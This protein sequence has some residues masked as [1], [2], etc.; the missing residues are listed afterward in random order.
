MKII[1]NSFRNAEDGCCWNESDFACKFL[2]NSPHCSLSTKSL[3]ERLIFQQK[4]KIYLVPL[5]YVRGR[6]QCTNW[7]RQMSTPHHKFD[8]VFQRKWIKLKC[9]EW[10]KKMNSNGNVCQWKTC[11]TAPNG[12]GAKNRIKT[13]FFFLL[14]GILFLLMDSRHG[15]FEMKL[16]S[17]SPWFYFSAGDDNNR[18]LLIGHARVNESE[19]PVEIS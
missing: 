3:S 8:M 11:T 1:E 5:F 13:H 9:N 12:G 15:T 19:I 14:L 6:Y 7:R 18:L 16:R 4:E 2:I 10:L 17:R